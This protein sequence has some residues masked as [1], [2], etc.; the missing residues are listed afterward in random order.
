M[1]EI[2]PTRD[3]TYVGAITNTDSWSRFSLRPD[4]VIISTPP[5]C[6]TTW[7]QTIVVMLLSG[8]ATIDGPLG[9]VSPWLDCAFRDRVEIAARLAGQTHRRCIKSHTPLDGIT[10]NADVTYITVYRHPMDVHFSMRT[11][12][13]NMQNDWLDFMYT[14]D[15]RESFLRFVD[16]PETTTGTDDLTVAS[17]AAHYRTFRK[18]AALPNIHFFHYADMTRDRLGQITRLAK[19]LNL[20]H[21]QDLLTAVVDATSFDTMQSGAKQITYQAGDSAFAVPSKFFDSGSS[22]KWEDKLTAEDIDRYDSRIRDLLPEDQRH[23]LEWRS[24]V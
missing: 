16:F 20:N 23:W 4:D 6:G 15:I 8:R 5:K 2:L 3:K 18:W 22:N 24:S 9:D 11:H 10:Y 21:N 7:M 14:D 12:A 13:A 19:L 17:I 1:A